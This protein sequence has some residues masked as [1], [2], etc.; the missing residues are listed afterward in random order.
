MSSELGSNTS[1]WPKR[2]HPSDDGDVVKKP[3]VFR[4]ASLLLLSSTWILDVPVGVGGER[5]S[6]LEELLAG[7]QHVLN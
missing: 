3:E 7:N 2:R 6:R 5:E 4:S 1:E